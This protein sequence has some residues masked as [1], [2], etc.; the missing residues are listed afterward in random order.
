MVLYSRVERLNGSFTNHEC[1]R[2]RKLEASTRIDSTGYDVKPHTT[3]IVWKLRD[4]VMGY[5]VFPFEETPDWKQRA[6]D[7]DLIFGIKTKTVLPDRTEYRTGSML[8]RE[9]GPA[10]EF[11]DGTKMWYWGGMLH[12]DSVEGPAIEY[13]NGEK[14]WFQERGIITPAK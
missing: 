10:V 3:D 5:G 1:G 6:M 13:A 4:V 9:D 8:H 12:R 11:N 14:R 2:R 7:D